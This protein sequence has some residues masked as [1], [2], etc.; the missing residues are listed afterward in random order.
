MKELFEII[1]DHMEAST[2]ESERQVMKEKTEVVF[3]YSNRIINGVRELQEKHKTFIKKFVY[4]QKVKACCLIECR[5]TR[6]I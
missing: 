6:G 1:E 5:I 2:D 4:R 3:D